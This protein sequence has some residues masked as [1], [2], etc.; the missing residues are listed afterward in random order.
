MIHQLL[1]TGSANDD[2]NLSAQ[3]LRIINDSEQLNTARFISWYR[4]SADPCRKI[5]AQVKQ[6]K[7]LVAKMCTFGRRY[8]EEKGKCVDLNDN[9]TDKYLQYTS[10]LKQISEWWLKFISPEATYNK[11]QWT[12]QHSLIISWNR[13]SE[14]PCRKFRPKLN[15]KNA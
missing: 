5:Q 9:I 15:K 8:V 12:A 10:C 3:K 11:R 6:K 1:K 14:D 7:C 4:A 13:A 2:S